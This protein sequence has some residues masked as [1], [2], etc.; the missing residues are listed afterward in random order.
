MLC[1]QTHAIACTECLSSVHGAWGSVPGN[2]CTGHGGAHLLAQHLALE[3]GGSRI[4]PILKK[5]IKWSLVFGPM[6]MALSIKCSKKCFSWLFHCV[7]LPWIQQGGKKTTKILPELHPCNSDCEVA[8]EAVQKPMM[9][10]L[11]PLCR[12]W[13]PGHT[14]QHL[15]Q[16]QM[17][18]AGLYAFRT[19]YLF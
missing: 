8:S 18:A 11:A 19:L 5:K 13:A 15:N 3:A 6:H 9:K 10:A 2:V 1:T 14:S 12:P 4:D 17:P 7:C 16:T